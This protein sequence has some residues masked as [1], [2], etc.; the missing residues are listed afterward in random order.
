MDPTAPNSF[1]DECEAVPVNLAPNAPDLDLSTSNPFQASENSHHTNLERTTICRHQHLR[2]ANDMN[3]AAYD[4]INDW[5]PSGSKILMPDFGGHLDCT[6]E[7]PLAPKR[8][9][10]VRRR[11]FIG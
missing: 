5:S 8:F 11:A 10:R 2:T 3:R 1:P 9:I 6:M 7:L 4:L